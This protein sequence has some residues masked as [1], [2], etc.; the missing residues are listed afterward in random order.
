MALQW[1]LIDPEGEFARS[2]HSADFVR[3]SV[4]EKTDP[5][6]QYANANI[7][8]YA[9]SASAMLELGFPV[10][11]FESEVNVAFFV[12]EVSLYTDTVIIESRDKKGLYLSQLGIGFRIG[13]VTWKADVKGSANVGLVAASTQIG[14]GQSSVMVKQYGLT[15]ESVRIIQPLMAF[16]EIN[17]DFMRTLSGCAGQLT[18]YLA[19]H[20]Q[21][22]TPI[23]L[24]AAPLTEEA[25]SPL[26]A[27]VAS[28]YV[29]QRIR[30]RQAADA[31]EPWFN[32]YPKYRNIVSPA[33]VA[34]GYRTL[35][36]RNGS[37]V[38][39]DSEVQEANRIDGLGR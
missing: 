11:K 3:R 37:D 33:I 27:A 18:E 16:G 21:E 5:G 20:G 8:T 7:N 17:V 15:D 25:Y 1:R 35:G 24:K 23:A 9:F 26:N 38:P 32:A 36:I 34:A 2:L 4:L 28:N 29:V 13:S 6:Q 12:T 14:S 30:R 19:K 22:M 39:T 10:A 31:N